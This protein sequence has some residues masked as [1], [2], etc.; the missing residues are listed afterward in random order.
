MV[1]SSEKD[2][3]KPKLVLDKKSIEAEVKKDTP[4]GKVVIER[5][6]GTDYGFI[7]GKE[8]SADVV[9]TEA[10]ERA[11]GISLFFQGIGSFF[12]NLWSGITDFVGGL[13]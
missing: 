1:K 2:L 11:N 10:V 12:G 8:L 7:D 13:F 5:S 3:Y 6:E 9:T 4:V